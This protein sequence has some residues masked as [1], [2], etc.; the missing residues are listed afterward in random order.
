M[1]SGLFNSWASAHP[2]R[3]YHCPLFQRCYRSEAIVQHE[4]PRFLYTAVD[5]GP[6]V[7]IE[8]IDVYPGWSPGVVLQDGLEG[9]IQRGNQPLIGSDDDLI[10]AVL[11][12][13]CRDDVK[14]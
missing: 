9:F 2:H 5:F 6:A 12:Q 7:P 11:I 13:F 3:P 8:V 4:Q 10:P 1:L 14:P